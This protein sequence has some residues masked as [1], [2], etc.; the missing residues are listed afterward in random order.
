[1]KNKKKLHSKLFI[2][3]MVLLLSTTG[4]FA[5]VP[6]DVQGKSYE[7]AV[8]TLMEKG[9]I[10]G[11]TDGNFYPESNLTRAQ[12]CVII[13]KS[14][15][16]SAVDVTGTATQPA[17]DSGFGD[18]TGYGWAE[19]Y[20]AYAVEH[21]VTNGYPDGTF[22]PGNPVKINE[23]ITMA[24]RAATYSDEVLGG[25]WPSNYLGKA[26]ELNLLE[27]L[28]GNPDMAQSYA[29]KWM[30]AQVDYNLL[31]EI[32]KAN[33]QKEPSGSDQETPSNVPDTDSM[34]YVNGSF[35]SD[36]TTF[37]GK[38]LADDAVVYSYEL[39]KNY[40]SKMTFSKKSAD[41]RTETVYKY[42][43]V[44]T[45]AFYKTENN[46]IVSM[47]VPKDIGYSGWAYVVINGTITTKNAKGDTVPGLEV[48]AAAR[49]IKWVG[50]KGLS[51]P[52]KTGSSSYLNGTV[53]ELRIKKGEIQSVLTAANHKGKYFEELTGGSFEE[54]KSF[55]NNV[56]EFDNGD[57]YEIK[58]NATVYTMD[59]GNQKEYNVGKQSNIKK[60][61]EIRIYDI[62]DD[63]EAAGNLVVV[64]T[65]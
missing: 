52:S 65:K 3:I 1:M 54:I 34:T 2:M 38:T 41:Y 39:E 17:P 36:M 57:L 8:E 26:V 58:D 21:G 40:G 19:G 35:D 10:T 23:L 11:D 13:V 29:T 50:E 59:D 7:Q 22:K 44:E 4:V 47:V 53:Y 25:T 6:D 14:M 28:E 33:P 20:I 61:N 32:E 42:K 31:D 55:K 51:V 60:G 49:E 15:N 5:A 56:V 30:A 18:M 64:L 9:I 27:G 62:S 43:N 45:P 24:L 48:L 12:A 37:N 16:P 63:D 46:K